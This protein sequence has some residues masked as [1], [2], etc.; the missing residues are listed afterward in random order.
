M[1]G[2]YLFIFFL[3]ILKKSYPAIVLETVVIDS[4]II[5]FFSNIRQNAYIREI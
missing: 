3:E 5:V 4:V 1:G 2:K